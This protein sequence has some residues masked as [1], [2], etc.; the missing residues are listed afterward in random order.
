MPTT[1]TRSLIGDL[2]FHPQSLTAKD[3]KDTRKT[4]ASPRRTRRT[5][6][7][8]FRKSG[9]LKGYLRVLGVL[10]GKAVYR[11]L[12]RVEADV[13]LLHHL[14]PTLDFLVDEHRELLRVAVGD[15]HRVVEE[16]RPHIV[17][18]ED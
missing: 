4:K 9:F 1:P 18:R 3:A 8:A 2:P 16:V 15:F 17:R 13:R 7:N 14:R 11:L 12:F 10:C 6:R 5:Q